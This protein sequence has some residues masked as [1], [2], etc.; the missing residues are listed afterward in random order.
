[1]P[2][3]PM[4]IKSGTLFLPRGHYMFSA[5]FTDLTTVVRCSQERQRQL[6]F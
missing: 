1:M 4:N 5:Y 6:P 2:H 3:G